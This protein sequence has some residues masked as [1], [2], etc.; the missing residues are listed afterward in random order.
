MK[1]YLTDK[2]CY[3]DDELMGV[4]FIRLEFTGR[5]IIED[6]TSTDYVLYLYKNTLNIIKKNKNS[7][8]AIRLL[9]KYQG[10]LHISKGIMFV[11][12]SNP[13]PIKVISKKF[14]YSSKNITTISEDMGLLSE[15]MKRFFP[16][17]VDKPRLKTNA[18]T[19]INLK[20]QLFNKDGSNYEGLAHM[21]LEGPNAL[22]YYS[23]G[24]P[25]KDSKLLYGKKRTNVIKT[26]PVSK[27][28]REYLLSIEKSRKKI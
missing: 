19:N 9:F 4:R 17:K 13:K 16:I 27:N 2:D 3:L 12:S 21:I 18:V 22:A 15:E 24:T 7:T 11:G 26:A 28:H 23:G 6:A 8:S 14:Q 25:S 20:R 10:T 5:P 1:I